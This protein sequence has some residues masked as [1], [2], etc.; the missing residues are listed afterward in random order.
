MPSARRNRSKPKDNLAQVRDAVS[1]LLSP[2]IFEDFS[3]HGNTS[4]LPA[5][6][7]FDDLDA[8]IQRIAAPD[9][10]LPCASTME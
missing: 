2:G 10:P 8:P 5:E 9:T 4:W 7:A 6:T 1:W 3:F